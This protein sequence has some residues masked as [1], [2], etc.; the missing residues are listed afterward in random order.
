MG[1]Q[2][3]QARL[4]NYTAK[5]S[6]HTGY[7]SVCVCVCVCPLASDREGGR[8]RRREREEHLK[9]NLLQNTSE[10]PFPELS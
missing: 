8:E 3:S 6:S 1:W 10:S 9:A 2:E 5:N 4:S 7:V